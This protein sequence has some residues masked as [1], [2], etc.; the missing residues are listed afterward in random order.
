MAF[1]DIARSRFR[2]ETNSLDGMNEADLAAFRRNLI[3]LTG[4]WTLSGRSPAKSDRD[5]TMIERGRGLETDSV[6]A[7]DEERIVV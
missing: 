6:L 1:F 3:A 7:C 2:G 4:H 5:E